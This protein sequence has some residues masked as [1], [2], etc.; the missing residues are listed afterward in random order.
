M[1]AS[2]S[3]FLVFSVM[4]YTQF[5]FSAHRVLYQQEPQRATVEEV[6]N[7]N[8]IPSIMQPVVDQLDEALKKATLRNSPRGI[9]TIVKIWGTKRERSF[10]ENRKK[11]SLAAMNAC[12]FYGPYGSG[13]LMAIKAISQECELPLFMYEA[14]LMPRS[15]RIQLLQRIFEKAAALKSPCLL[16]IRHL[17]AFMTANGS[18]TPEMIYLLCLLDAYKDLPIL[19]IGTVQDKECFSEGLVSVFHH[20]VNVFCQLNTNQRKELIRFHMRKCYRGD[21]NEELAQELAEKTDGYAYHSLEGLVQ[22]ANMNLLVRTDFHSVRIQREDFIEVLDRC[23]ELGKKKQTFWKTL[24][25]KAKKWAIPAAIVCTVVCG[26]F[27]GH[28]YLKRNLLLRKI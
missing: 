21:D 25:I 18:S 12:L 8:D 17:E 2:R 9:E 10:S 27:F 19:F 28:K 7:N 4:L 13:K 11:L 6:N 3:V 26:L 1:K 5:S 22:H 24:F 23:N 14:F 20:N 16:C 15:D